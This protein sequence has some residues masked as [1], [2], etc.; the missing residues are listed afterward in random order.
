MATAA[1]N[2][3]PLKAG[4]DGILD[5]IW[6]YPNISSWR[7]GSWFWGQG[8]TKSLAG[9]RD[10]VNNVLLAKDFKLEDI[11]NVAWD[12]INDLLAQISPNA[13]EGEGWVETS[14][15]IE[16]PTGI[17][18]K[19]GEQPQNNHQ[20]AKSFS[21]PGLWHHSIPALISS[22]FS[23]DTAA[24]SFHFNPFKQFWKTSQGW[25]EHV[26]DELFNSDAWLRAH[27][28]VE[29]L[30]REEGDTL[31]RCIAALMFWSDATHLAQFGQAKLWPIYLF[32]GNQS[33]WI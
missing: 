14:V 22:V 29:A 16:V 33:K 26:R 9:F 17:K 8:D 10:L 24:E 1:V 32:F 30:P 6:P 27:E 4:K 28:E 19:A 13:P 18:K 11:Q 3:Q 15:D 2:S 23:G 12:K 31:P 5:A 7:L 20:A 25:L 21:V